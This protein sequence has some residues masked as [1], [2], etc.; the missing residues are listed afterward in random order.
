MRCQVDDDYLLPSQVHIPG[1]MFPRLQSRL[2][3][4]FMFQR[5]KGSNSR[6]FR[7]PA[8]VDVNYIVIKTLKGIC[9]VEL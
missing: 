3:G 6:V 5:G 8:A 4:Q 1:H 7:S 9:L 2:N